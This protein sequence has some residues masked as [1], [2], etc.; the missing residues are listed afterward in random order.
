MYILT[1]LNVF[2]WYI[3]MYQLAGLQQ[4]RDDTGINRR[5]W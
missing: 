4:K 1:D 5:I 2:N 3:L